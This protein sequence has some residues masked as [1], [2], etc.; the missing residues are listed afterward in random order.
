MTLRIMSNKLFLEE[1]QVG[2][3]SKGKTI[4]ASILATGGIALI[5]L[6]MMMTIQPPAC[7]VFA[8][9]PD[10]GVETKYI[11]IGA[12]D[13]AES[14]TKEDEVKIKGVRSDFLAK[15]DSLTLKE[16]EY[17]KVINQTSTLSKLD[18]SDEDLSKKIAA[19]EF[20]QNL[21]KQQLEEAR[22]EFNFAQEQYSSQL[23]NIRV[24]APS[25]EKRQDLES[26]VND[27]IPIIELD[28]KIYTWTDRVYLTII[29]PLANKNV[30]EIDI[31]G[32]QNER[33]IRVTTDSGRELR[34]MLRETGSDTGI[35]TG[36]ITLTGIPGIDANNDGKDDTSGGSS[37]FGGP[38]DGLLSVQPS[39]GIS[40]FYEYDKCCTAI[41]SALVRWNIG[42]IYFL[43]SNYQ[44]NETTVI[45]VIDPD[46]NVNPV[47]IDFVKI[48]VSSESDP[49]G[50]EV[51]LQETNE[52][53]GMFEGSIGFTKEKSGQN[54]LRTSFGE[55]LTATY[56]DKTLPD[57]YSISEH[58][59][60]MGNATINET[61]MPG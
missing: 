54:I 55:L 18:N 35:F 26:F 36:E 58:L 3:L 23:Q 1:N 30:D 8:Q 38:T 17:Q 2:L 5:A 9:S 52:A 51:L 11:P 27:L 20:K 59:E 4:I 53:T 47:S 7:V 25:E 15:G 44:L 19:F 50:I 42:E 33:S 21:L 60:L 48:T 16:E 6:Y 10:G 12:E 37:T 41:S 56:I 45:R 14:L 43:K 31:I 29:N 46:L 61:L 57:P 32:T 34:Y 13:C 22:D 28:Q 40:V 49:K 24:V 39:D